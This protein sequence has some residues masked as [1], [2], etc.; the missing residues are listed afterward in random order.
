MKKQVKVVLCCFIIYISCVQTKIKEQLNVD[1]S[2]PREELIWFT[3]KGS[4][5]DSVTGKGIIGSMVVIKKWWPA[6]GVVTDSIGNFILEAGSQDSHT[7]AAFHPN[8]ETV[9][10]HIST[11][12]N[13]TTVI[14]FFLKP[15]SPVDTNY[16]ILTGKI[17][18]A[19]TGLSLSD[20]EVYSWYTVNYASTDLCGRYVIYNLVPGVYKMTVSYISYDP[21]IDSNIV[22][23]PNQTTTRNY[24][25]KPMK[26]LNKPIY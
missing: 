5:K 11:A 12:M 23:K 26:M 25:L 4:V 22:I 21:M 14:N 9:Y 8:Y 24:S 17:V 15:I 1:I 16:G 10:A 3:I 2:K 18:D 7:I 20:V 19:K 13:E 6:I